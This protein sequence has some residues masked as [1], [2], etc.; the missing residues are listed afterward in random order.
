MVQGVFETTSGCKGQGQVSRK[1]HFQSGV[2]VITSRKSEEVNQ[3]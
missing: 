2:H 1:E 3:A